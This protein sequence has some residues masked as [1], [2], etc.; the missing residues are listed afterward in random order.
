V[1]VD[2][3]RLT[4]DQ[5]QSELRKTAADVRASFGTLDDR[6]LNWR[7]DP[8]RWSVAQ[9][10][11]HL[12]QS[13]DEMCGA[14]ERAADP[15]R[16]RTIWQRLPIL[17]G[18]I[19]RMMVSSLGPKVTRKFV[20]PSQSTPSASDSDS[21]VLDRF[22]ASQERVLAITRTLAGRDLDRMILVSPFVKVVTYS[23]FDGLRLVVAHEHR[24]VE[25]ARRVREAPGF[26]RS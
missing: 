1:A 7:P 9:C 13:N 8:S 19:G 21:G 17:P 25:Q 26:P 11:Q 23:V 24:H 15:A 10:L 6:Q 14:F 18:V 2:Y 16:P 5:I 4:L 12:V 22:A 20:A 3:L